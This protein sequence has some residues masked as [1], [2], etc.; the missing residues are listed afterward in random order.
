MVNIVRAGG[1]N[2]LASM[3]GRRKMNALSVRAV[4]A[5]P[6]RK[7][8][9]VLAPEGISWWQDWMDHA[10]PGDPWWER[11][12]LWRGG[13]NDA[14]HR[15]G[16][17]A[18]TTCFYLSSCAISRCA[19]HAGRDVRITIGPW[20]HVALP[21]M[22]N[23]YARAWRYFRSDLASRPPAEAKPRVRLFL[24]GANKWR[25]YSSLASTE[26]YSSHLIFATLGRL[27]RWTRPPQKARAVSITIPPIPRRRC[28]ARRSKR[29]KARA[30]WRNWNGARMSWFLQPTRWHRTST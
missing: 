17:A 11:D 1:A 27:C 16:R 4:A 7:A 28:M 24:M 18:G 22:L 30:I 21:G 10:E 19:Q 14:A 6:L 2:P 3:L 23:R 20:T 29:E 13:P 5:I 26:R 15:D 12:R 25:E 9:R 8:D